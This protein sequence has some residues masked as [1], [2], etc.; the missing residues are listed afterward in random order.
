MEAVAESFCLFTRKDYQSG[1][2]PHV[3]EQLFT[4]LL[5]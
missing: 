2:L 3:I 4:Q 5:A 1:T